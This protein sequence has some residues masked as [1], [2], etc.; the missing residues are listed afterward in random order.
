[1][2]YIENTK[3]IATKIYNHSKKAKKEIENY[4]NKMKEIRKNL[5]LEIS[6]L[7]YSIQHELEIPY[8]LYL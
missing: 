4:T 6:N 3:E 1:M 5:D 2:E 7:S 8:N